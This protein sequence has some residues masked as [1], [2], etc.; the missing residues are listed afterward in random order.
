[1]MGNSGGG[2]VT[3]FAAACDERIDI[4]VPS[5]SFAPTV[6]DAGYIFHCDC[7]MVPGLLELGG[8]PGVCGLIAPR[9]LLAVNGRKDTL[10]SEEVVEKAAA[11]VHNMYEA[12]GHP[13]R[14][15]HRWGTEGHRF[16]KDLMWS[17]V[18]EAKKAKTPR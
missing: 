18:K 10:F 4:A 6:S 2:M 13:E 1:M 7:N 14:F 11:T 17:F 12:A 3:M 16:Y 15:E 5:C 8:L 9:R